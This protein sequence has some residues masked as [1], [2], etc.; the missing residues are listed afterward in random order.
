[1]SFDVTST[2][3]VA[4]TWVIALFDAYLLSRAPGDAARRSTTIAAVLAALAMTTL[5]P[6]VYLRLDRAVGIPNI[7][8]TVGNGFGIAS[9]WAFIPVVAR[10]ARHGPVQRGVFGSVWLMLAAVGALVWC[11]SRADLPV[12]DPYDF[13]ERYGGLPGVA[14]AR[15]VLF[16][17]I[18]VI[19]ARLLALSL[20]NDADVRQLP[21]RR[22]RVQARLQTIGWACATAYA[23]YQ[24]L[25]LGLRASGIAPTLP[26]LTPLGLGLITGGLLALASG[27]AFRVWAWCDRL[28]VYRRLAP[29]GPICG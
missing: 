29:S 22:D 17:Y 23:L 8:R 5:Y 4:L 1:M 2:V 6:S 15:L 26:Y 11:Y 12:S 16:A 18:G 21:R 20:R 10:L 27:L 3:I 24:C 13:Q 28:R 19:F 14:A 7:A 25:Y 9:A